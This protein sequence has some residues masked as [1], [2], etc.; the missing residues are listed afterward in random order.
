M[1]KLFLN[2]ACLAIGAAA[3]AQITL[4]PMPGGL[5]G[6]P[7]APK[8]GPKPYKEV[9][10]DKAKTQKGLVTVH[11]LEDK[12]FFEIADSIF[13]REIM[14]ITRIAKTATNAGYGGEEANQQV[15]KFEKG[16]ENKVFI[17]SILYINV[18]TDSVPIFQAV[19]NSNVDPIAASMDIKALRMDSATKTGHT[20]VEVTDLIKGDNPIV[21][22]A[23]FLKR[24][25]S[26]SSPASDRTFINYIKTFPMNTE[27]RVTRTYNSS[28]SFNPFAA[29]S[30]FPTAPSLP[31]ANQA[32]AVTLEMNSSFILLPKKPAQRRMYDERVGY[33][34]DGYNN[35]GL[36]EQKTKSERFVTRWKL[37]PK[38]GEEAKY[39]SGELVEPQKPIV[40][41]IDPA[42]PVQW[43]K[44][45][46][47]GVDDWAV[48][49]EKAGWK[50]AIRG[51]YWP[52]KD[53]TMSLEDARF[54]AIRYF[55]SDVQNAYGP[56]VH[57]PRSGEIL[58]SHIGWYH[59]VMS[60]VHD[61]YMIQ[62]AAVDPRA[63]KVK[64][65]EELMGQLIRFVSSHEVGHTIGLQHN[66]G[67]SHATP[68]EKLRDK[69]WVEANGHT[70]SI[71]DYAR[72]NYVAQPEDNIS[73]VGLFPRIGDYD[74][75]AIEWAYRWYGKTEEEEKKILNE[76]TKQKLQNPRLRYL[77]Q[78]GAPVDP[79]AQ[80]EDLSDNSV[81]ASEY[82]IKNL[83]RIL[84][85]LNEWTKETGE[86]FENL[87][88]MYQNVIFQF[89]RYA[90]HV[91]ANIGG[92]Y[93]EPK[94]MEQEGVVY[95]PVPKAIQK[96][97]MNFLLKNVFET[98]TWLLDWNQLKKFDQDQ[99]LENI[100]NMQAA[101]LNSLLSSSRLG[102]I[103]ENVAVSAPNTAY[104]MDEMMDDL[105]KG[106]W[107]EVY[108]KKAVDIYRRGLQKA[109]VDRLGAVINQP[110]NTGG[111]F[112]SFGPTFSIPLSDIVSVAKGTLRTLRSDIKLALPLIGDRM[113]KYH[114]QD[115]LDR[116]DNI[117]D[118]KK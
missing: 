9:I 45:L 66:M 99:T 55:A 118:P 48:A 103:S 28:S 68:V 8:A 115:V 12:Y 86:D 10:T 88:T 72:F 14:V 24:A 111:F 4:P 57:D 106:I 91:T 53:S 7:S 33:F 50:N 113:S 71:M 46:K 3:Q 20:V 93:E 82:G 117:L 100:R 30:P 76:L 109:F 67:A 63:R 61:W 11:K 16:P 104:G 83:K 31:A 39:L 58:E 5:G 92:I 22:M 97:A 13:E 38:K 90:G 37:E 105:R 59:N 35:Y 1:R 23:S 25:Y 94:T 101:T 85:N 43:R 40:Y 47:Q 64:F 110:A 80:T 44:Y 107:S 102:R 60:L 32:G 114:L 29:P 18:A 49:F 56:E 75:W 21:S 79:R 54:S 116:I 19:R 84:P 78:R 34:S 112:V 81:K 52:E 73:Q 70:S 17:R 62:T 69:A 2:L 98:P 27:V 95:T 108:A 26:L 96:D 65:D 87:A 77:R 51:E 6:G 89:R 42:T 15:I 36:N 41:Y 74:I